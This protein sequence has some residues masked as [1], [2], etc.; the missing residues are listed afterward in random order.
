MSLPS[1]IWTQ[2]FDL[3]TDDDALSLRPILTSFAESAW[4]KVYWKMYIGSGDPASQWRVRSPEQI[5][6]ILQRRNYATKKVLPLAIS[7]F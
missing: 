7:S 4:S 6:D 3:A 5:R 1:E 2:I